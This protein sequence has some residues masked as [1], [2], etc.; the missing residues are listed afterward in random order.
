MGLR[1]FLF[2]VVLACIAGD[3]AHAQDIIIGARPQP[4]GEK[5]IL[6]PA[7]VKVEVWSKNLKAPWSLA[8]LP[9]GRGLVSERRGTIR[10]LSANGQYANTP[11]FTLD[12][13]ED[14]ESGLMGLAVHPSFPQAPFV[15]AMRTYRRRTT[16]NNEVLR[17][18]FDG[19]AMSLDKILIADIP[20]GNNHNGGRLG[21]GPD[22]M[23]YVGTGDIFKRRLS[24]DLTSLAGKILRIDE[25]GLVPADNPFPD[26]PIWSWGH[27]NVQGLAWDPKTG[28]FYNT[29]HGPS[30]EV[31]FGAFDEVNLVEKGGNFGWPLV[32]GAGNQRVVGAGNQHG[33]LDPIVAWPEDA[34]PPSGAAF[35]N[36]DI[37]IATLGQGLI[38]IQLQNER[39]IHVDRWFNDGDN[40]VY[41]RLRDAVQGPGGALYVLTGNNDWRGN[42]GPDDDRILRLSLK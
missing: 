36:G 38:R 19:H 6:K 18:Y 29:E 40:S 32:V 3:F 2:V 5:F 39:A 8:F 17:L 35:W 23:L 37:F 20:A 11:L 4:A 16:W 24:Q 34:V 7:G 31:G 1:S 22:G 26:S 13:A 27:R 41:G 21:F 9:D 12:V 10:L 15:Y 42:P 25:N 14:D 30:G 28:A 33:M